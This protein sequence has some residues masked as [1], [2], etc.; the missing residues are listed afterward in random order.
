MPMLLV[1]EALGVK[2]ARSL[3]IL[4]FKDLVVFKISSSDMHEEVVFA[5]KM[6]L[7]GFEGATLPCCRIKNHAARTGQWHGVEVYTARGHSECW[8]TGTKTG[9]ESSRF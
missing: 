2:L 9:I 3:S 7:L 4:I 6:N 5:A 8:I 1:Y